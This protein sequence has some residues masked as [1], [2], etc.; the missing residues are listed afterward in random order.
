MDVMAQTVLCHCDKCAKLAGRE[1]IWTCPQ[2]TG[3]P[4]GLAKMA[5][6]RCRS[7]AEQ[8]AAT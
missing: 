8:K 1:R 4:T 2:V 6:L 3:L 7:H 5:L